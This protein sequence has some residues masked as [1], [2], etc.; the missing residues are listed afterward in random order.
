MELPALLL[1]S[2]AMRIIIVQWRSHRCG[3]REDN[4]RKELTGL[5]VAFNGQ[6]SRILGNV[7]VNTR[8]QQQLRTGGE[9]DVR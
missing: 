2:A 9:G 5:A 7:Q 6:H 8:Q 1:L 3:W 4:S